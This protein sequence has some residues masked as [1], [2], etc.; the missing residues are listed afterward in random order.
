MDDRAG[1]WIPSLERVAQPVVC[2]TDIFQN[3]H[4]ERELAGGGSKLP[5]G[6]VVISWEELAGGGSA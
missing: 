4:V 5:E 6:C 3:L 2:L 1:L